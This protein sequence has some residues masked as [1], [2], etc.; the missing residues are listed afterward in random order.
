MMDKCKLNKGDYVVKVDF[1]GGTYSGYIFDG[2][3]YGIGT[4][5]NA[6]CTERWEGLWCYDN[7]CAGIG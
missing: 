3:R 2:T 5:V 6:D 1:D 7:F 4:W